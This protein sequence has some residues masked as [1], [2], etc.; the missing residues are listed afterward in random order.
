MESG[1]V[2]FREDIDIQNFDRA[3]DFNSA[4]ECNLNIHD[5]R[6]SLTTYDQILNILKLPETAPEY[7]D[8][9]FFNAWL[10]GVTISEGSFFRLGR[11]KN[12]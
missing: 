6:P 5:I 10:I 12:H 8:L 11:V 9:R 2:K 3:I 1:D 7:L 4:P